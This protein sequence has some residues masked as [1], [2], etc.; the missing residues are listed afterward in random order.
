[1]FSIVQKD[2]VNNVK[3]AVFAKETL[4]CSDYRKGIILLYKALRDSGA[5]DTLLTI[6][7]TGVELS[8]LL[9][10]CPDK[11]NP[12]SILRLH[13]VSFVH[14]MYCIQ[15]FG[16]PNTMTSRRFFGRYFHS[17]TCHAAMTY[18]LITLSKH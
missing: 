14:G 2:A 7:K 18:R 8:E 16:Q 11:R 4:R 9:Y 12:T 17:L 1:M 3:E 6:F 13:N 5:D 10:A 15:V